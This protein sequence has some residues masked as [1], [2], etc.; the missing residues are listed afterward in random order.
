MESLRDK[1]RKPT[2][3]GEILREDILP[4]LGM[5]QSE[6][7][8]RLHVSRQTISELLREQRSLTPD[9]AIRLSRLVGG[10]ASGWLRMQQAV[11][12]WEV[13]HADARIYSDI[14][15]MRAPKER[16]AS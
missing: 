4:S 9:I 6:F 5:N 11:D 7:S 13:E 1:H 15:K 16:K 2:H 10:T 8:K 3:P 12:L 14:K